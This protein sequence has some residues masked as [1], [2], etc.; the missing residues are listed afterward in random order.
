MDVGMQLILPKLFDSIING[1]TEIDISFGINSDILNISDG[2]IDCSF[3]DVPTNK[4]PA[5]RV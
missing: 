4:H 3:T 2:V 5:F 1:I